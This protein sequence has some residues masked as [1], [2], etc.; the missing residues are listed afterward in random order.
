[1]GAGGGATH[2]AL[3]SNRGVLSNYSSYANELLIVAGGGA[4]AYK[5]YHYGSGTAGRGNGNNSGGGGGSF[6]QGS[7]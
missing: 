5:Y 7:S 2:I 3:N 6:G 1:M 4:G